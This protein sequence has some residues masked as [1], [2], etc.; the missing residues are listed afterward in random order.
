MYNIS[1]ITNKYQIYPICPIYWTVTIE[2]IVFFHKCNGLGSFTFVQIFNRTKKNYDAKRIR[3]YIQIYPN[4]Y[5]RY[6]I[7][8]YKIPSGG[9]AAAARPGPEPQAAGPRP[10]RAA[11]GRAGL[12]PLGILYIYCISCIYL[13]IFRYICC[14]YFWYFFGMV[15][16]QGPMWPKAKCWPS[17]QL[18]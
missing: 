8:I 4:I 3:K 1:K 12:P 14:I 18:G 15:T 9:Q 13:D 11:R 10:A 5:T 2:T 16:T 6:T 7:H 17:T